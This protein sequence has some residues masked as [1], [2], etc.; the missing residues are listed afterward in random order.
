MIRHDRP[1]TPQQAEDH[2]DME[3][4]P[5]FRSTAIYAGTVIVVAL[6]VGWLIGRG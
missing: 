3:R 2:E 1:Y 4:D 5:D 6:V